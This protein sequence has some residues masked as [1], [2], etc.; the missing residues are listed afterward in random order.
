LINK[1]EGKRLTGKS[2]RKWDNITTDFRKREQGCGLEIF[3]PGL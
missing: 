1:H 2:K 3:A